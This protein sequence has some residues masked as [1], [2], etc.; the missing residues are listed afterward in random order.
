MIKRISPIA[1]VAVL[2]LQ[3]GHT[4]VR[5]QESAIIQATA[6]V[7]SSLTIVGSN[8]LQFGSV[9][10][11]VSKS[12]DKATIG[13]AGEWQISGAGSA[14]ISLDFTLPP[15]LLLIDSTVTMPI[16]FS[17]TDASWDDG[18]GGG[19]TAPVGDLNPLGPGAERLGAGGTMT[20]WI[21]GTVNPSLTQTGGD[22]AADIVLTVAYTGG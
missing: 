9:T 7:L 20:V 6:T 4:P 13:F 5:A 19:Q 22:Y 14:E 1:L 3:A 2:L 15:A 21:G 10:P 16:V 11:G 17:N 12:V 18:T 8:N